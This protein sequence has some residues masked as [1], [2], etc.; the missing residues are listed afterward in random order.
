MN[1][2]ITG[3]GGFIG[4]HICESLIRD[5]KLYRTFSS[6]NNRTSDNNAYAVNFEDELAVEK[7]IKDLTGRNIYAIIHLASQ[8]A[9]PNKL[10]NLELLRRNNV[11]SE[12]LAFLAKTL[13]PK[14]FINFS[15]MAIYPNVTGVFSEES[16][17]GP[18]S[19]RDC[20]YGLSKYCSE[21]IFDFL[22]KNNNINIIH[23]R[24]SNVNGAGMREIRL[25]PA[26]RKELET[27]NTI[28]VFGNGIRESNFIG[29]D[30]LVEV[31]KFFLSRK[32]TGVFNVG[33]QN[34]SYYNLAKKIAEKYGNTK[35]RIIKQPQGSKE[36]FNLDCSKL[37][38][39][40]R[41]N[42]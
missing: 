22:L 38:K 6:S 3:A 36:R 30:S 42:D 20:V 17:P 35:T 24:V 26:M 12:N 14:I 10:N 16:N 27:R 1:I 41:E 7:L 40:M 28:T 34:I 9:S 31:V 18:Q 8:M 19:N 33:E 11:I 21:I 23:L 39:L 25:I 37:K 4:T 15:S 5:H 29:I 2:L 13:K 32:V